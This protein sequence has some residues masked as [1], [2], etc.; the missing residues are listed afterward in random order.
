MIRILAL[1]TLLVWI[2]ACF[3]A[4]VVYP[5]PSQEFDGEAPLCCAFMD[6]GVD[7]AEEKL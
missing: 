1:T 5:P 3:Q 7:G 4:G 6:A 2:G